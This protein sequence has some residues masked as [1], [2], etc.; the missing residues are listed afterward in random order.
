MMGAQV[1]H[2]FEEIARF[3]T[4][5]TDRNIH[6]FSVMLDLQ[7]EPAALERL[8]AASAHEPVTVRVLSELYS[9]FHVLPPRHAACSACGRPFLNALS[10]SRLASR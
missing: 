9:Y 3:K 1:D 7:N 2:F 4:P 8:P 10:P 6:E 5:R